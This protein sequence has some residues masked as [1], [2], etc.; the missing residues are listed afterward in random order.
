MTE[1]ELEDYAKDAVFM[2]VYDTSWSTPTN[3]EK[4]LLNWVKGQTE[5]AFCKKGTATQG[6]LHVVKAGLDSTA[7]TRIV[8]LIPGCS[9][10]NVGKKRF[11]ELKLKRK[12]KVLK[13][14]VK[15]HAQTMF[16]MKKVDE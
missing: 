5:C 10:C 2:N 3:E 7:K 4:T 13:T 12:T 16:V 8:R 9:T 6:L 1:Y 15:C 14:N 11:G